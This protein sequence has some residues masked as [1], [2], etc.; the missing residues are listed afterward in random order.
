MPST[1]TAATSTLAYGTYDIAVLLKVMV[2]A[3]WPTSRALLDAA[4]PKPT[5]ILEIGCGSGES[6]RSL[7]AWAGPD[8][9]IVAVDRNA[10]SIALA[11]ATD[12]DSGAAGVEYRVLD[13]EREAPAWVETYDLVTV[14]FVLS[15]LKMPEAALR[16]VLPGLRRGG[17]LI[18][19]DIDVRGHFCHPPCDAFDRYVELYQA[20][21]RRRGGDACIGPRLPGALTGAG[22]HDVQLRVAL[23]TF[24]DGDGKRLALLAFSAIRDALVA[25]ELARPAELDRLITELDAYTHDDASIVSLPHIFQVWGRK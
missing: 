19:E 2:A 14:R 11:R 13:V 18:V 22:V 16:H 24:A 3:T 9:R 6:T 20:L 7:A 15:R 4:T 12:Q 8:A 23:P 5:R 21:A 1:A 25:A 10:A 17:T